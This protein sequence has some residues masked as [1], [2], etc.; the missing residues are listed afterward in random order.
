MAKRFKTPATRRLARR[1]NA[2][3][4]R[5]GR[6][7]GFAIFTVAARIDQVR[8]AAVSFTGPRLRGVVAGLDNRLT[9]RRLAMV[10]AVAAGILLLASQ[11]VD[12]RG[13]GIGQPEYEDVAAITAAPMAET[14][15]P[16]DAHGPLVAVLG[17]IAAVGTVAGL[18]GQGAR[19]R[20]ATLVGGAAALMAVAVILLVD[21]PQAGDVGVLAEQYADTEALLLEG[22]YAQLS[23]AA[24]LIFCAALPAFWALR[25]ADSPAQPTRKVA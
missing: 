4:R 3:L 5:G 7:V 19:S 22:F 13:V 12:Y 15:T 16:W 23:A 25:R 9:P 6:F 18:F 14:E 8:A 21:L 20:R 2:L 1:V 17:L 24:V 10:V 11:F